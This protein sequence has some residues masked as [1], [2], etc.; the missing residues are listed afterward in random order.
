MLSGFRSGVLR[1]SLFFLLQL[2]LLFPFFVS[3]GDPIRETH[4]NSLVLKHSRQLPVPAAAVGVVPAE[5]LVT[6]VSE[7]GWVMSEVAVASDARSLVQQYR[8]AAD[9]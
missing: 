1:S 7:S 3:L 6:L 4:K 2:R 8:Y 5:V 9:C